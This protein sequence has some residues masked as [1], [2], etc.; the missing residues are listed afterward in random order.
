MIHDATD[1]DQDETTEPGSSSHEGLGG[2]GRS[3]LDPPTDVF[4]GDEETETLVDDRSTVEADE[5]EPLQEASAPLSWRR[6]AGS[7]SETAP[8][9]PLESTS[10]AVPQT[11][12][13]TDPISAEPPPPEPAHP[14]GSGAGQFGRFILI[15]RLGRGGM[16]IVYDALD[17][18]R[19]CRVALKILARLDAASLTRFKR[20]FRA[21]ADLN[22]PNLVPL[23]ELFSEADQW[24]FTMER[25]EGT[26]F[27]SYVRPHGEDGKRRLDPARLREALRQLGLGLIAVHEAGLLHR[28]LKPSNVLVRPDGHVF[29]L[30]FG[31]VAALQPYGPEDDG[32]RPVLPSPDAWPTATTD[33]HLVGTVAY[34]PPE[35]AAGAPPSPAG[36]WYSVGI[37]LYEAL[38]GRRPFSGTT[39]EVL[40]AKQLQDPPAL[41]SLAPDLPADLVAL[42]ESLLDRRPEARLTGHQFLNALGRSEAGGAA[43]VAEPSRSVFIGRELPLATLGEAFR[44]TRARQPVTVLVHGRSGV[45]K[46]A[47]LH[48]FLGS[49]RPQEGVVILAGRCF[50][51]ESVPYKAIDTLIDALSQYLTRLPRDE[52]EAL[53]P[54]EISA[55][56]RIFPVLRRVPAIAQASRE[57]LDL[58]DQQESRRRAFLAWRT[59]L[60]RIAAR[61]TLILSIDDLQWGDR[62]SAVGLAELLRPPDPPCLMILVSYRSEYAGKS[63]CLERFQNG[64]SDVGVVPRVL[65]IGP[66]ALDEA[67][68]LALS[69]IGRDD[70]PARALADSIAKES[71]GNPYFI[72]ELARYV[73]AGADLAD[74]ATPD[75]GIDLER[76]L[77]SRIAGLPDESR[78]LLEVIALAGQPLAQRWAFRAAGVEDGEPAPLATLRSAK[79]V[80]SNG[81]RLDDEVES[82]H[83]RIRESVVSR[84][85]PDARRD[86]HRRLAEVLEAS[87]TTDPET[88]AVHFLG[89]GNPEAAAR[90]YILAADR[91]AEALAF[92]HAA[93]LYYLADTARPQEGEPVRA[94]RRKRADALAN[95]GRG[96]EAADLYLTNANLAGGAE[97]AELQRRAAYQYCISGHVDQGRAAFREILARIGLALP[98]SPR[99][100]LLSLLAHRSWLRIRGIGFRPRALETI[101]PE[102]LERI[103]TVWEVAIGLS[104]IDLIPGHDFLTRGLLLALR[105]G[106]PYRIVRSLALLAA[107]IATIGLPARRR[108]LR[109][110]DRAGSIGRDLD[111]PHASGMLALSRGIAEFMVGHWRACLEAVERAESVFMTECK[112]VAW[113]INT[114]R[115]FGLLSLADLGEYDELRR[116]W[117]EGL[118]RAKVRGDLYGQSVLDTQIGTQVRL[119]DGDPESARRELRAI[120]ARW[121]RDG[122]H[123]QHVWE[124]N[125]ETLIDL[126]LGNGRAAYERL[127]DR[128]PALK[129]SLFL[130]TQVPRDYALYLRAISALAAARESSDPA[131]LLDAARRDV[132]RLRSEGVPWASAVAELASAGVFAASGDTDAAIRG[133]TLA[134]DALDAVAMPTY[135]AASRRRL[136]ELVGGNRGQAQIAAAEADL[137][138]HGIREPSRSA[139]MYTG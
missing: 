110:L 109:L 63:E 103:D 69:A 132:A 102:E 133:Y 41:T 50:E 89:M 76:A 79:L 81:L 64:L 119:A 19:G 114:C 99:Q 87:G 56:A 68:E 96:I 61:R 8:Y 128:W 36:D 62:D 30:D 125:S 77:W 106:E 137:A 43:R 93:R 78:R 105:V 65:E 9:G 126:Y 24:F 28:D 90:Y 32:P 113:E 83:D 115:C 135:A 17:P 5:T 66:L 31:L 60:A 2:Y 59:L 98:R 101:T 16:G 46:T 45:G 127:R 52:A 111:H 42:C 112:G 75:R 7:D 108:A 70:P 6:I 57:V 22:H 44:A 20:E 21:R 97:R 40:L 38:S 131:P 85:D 14:V 88:L 23:F 55:L 116:R 67:R 107:N 84:L 10:A 130:R 33:V 37:M 12:L 117:S 123:L 47:L 49:I 94:L 74:L 92:D 54:E 4:G 80:R 1:S 13:A 48:R 27:L 58:A 72:D 139:A 86:R 53:L 129:K 118:Q 73:Q 25:V 82:F 51:Q 34:I 120:M 15:D 91:A 134:A 39:R 11:S 29:I 95:A 124:L 26:D 71:G 138:R 18:E 121:S 3:A 104:M 35:L 100:A 136:G 122:F